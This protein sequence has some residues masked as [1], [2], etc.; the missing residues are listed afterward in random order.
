M[1]MRPPWFFRKLNKAP[2]FYHLSCTQCDFAK[3]YELEN[4]SV[5]VRNPDCDNPDTPEVVEKLPKV[6]PNCGAKLDKEKIP[7]QIIY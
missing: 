6:C 2:K 3:E 1:L 4:G 7:V 5:V